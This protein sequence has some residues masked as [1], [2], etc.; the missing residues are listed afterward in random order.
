ML[1]I[2]WPSGLA[3][4]E[5]FLKSRG[6]DFQC[7]RLIPYSRG[8]LRCQ[9]G[10]DKITVRVRADRG[11]AWSAMV[12]EPGWSEQWWVATELRELIG[13]GPQSEPEHLVEED[14]RIIRD[15]WDAIVDAFTAENRSRS[16]TLLKSIRADRAKRRFGW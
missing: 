3:E 4:F 10:N 11:Y 14:I 8:E 1:P 9:Y 7:K 13:G 16:H 12:S 6:L 15:H 5:E 2:E